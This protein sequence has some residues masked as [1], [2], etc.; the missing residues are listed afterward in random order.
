M[1]CH[2]TLEAAESPCI[3]PTLQ[4]V[5]KLLEYGAHAS[6]ESTWR[7]ATGKVGTPGH[8]ASSSKIRTMLATAG[9]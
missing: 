3:M 4:V 8:H 5:S 2:H 1:R 9:M 6:M 7:D